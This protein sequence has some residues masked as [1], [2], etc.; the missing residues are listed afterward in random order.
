MP[1]SQVKPKWERKRVIRP[2]KKMIAEQKAKEEAEAPAPEPE[3][4]PES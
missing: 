4:Q 2:N 3:P 1:E